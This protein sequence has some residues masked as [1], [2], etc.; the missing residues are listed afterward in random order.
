VFWFGCDEGEAVSDANHSL[1]EDA[2]LLIFI[3]LN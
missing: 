2:E 1:D 3:S